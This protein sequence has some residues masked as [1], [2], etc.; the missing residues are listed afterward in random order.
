M[1]SHSGPS[2]EGPLPRTSIVV[3]AVLAISCTGAPKP[4]PCNDC[5]PWTPAPIPRP[6]ASGAASAVPQAAAV[7]SAPAIYS[8]EQLLKVR[9]GTAPRAIDDQAFVYLYDAPGTAQLHLPAAK[10]GDAPKQLT[11]YTDRVSNLRVAPGG[12]ELVFLKDQGGDENDQL[13]RLDLTGKEKDAVALT[14]RPKVKHTLPVF[15]GAAK[16]IAFTSNGRNGKDMDLYVQAWPGKPEDPG[17]AN[18]PLVEVSGNY[19][20]AD[21]VGERVLLVE[22]RSN[23]DQD[24]WVVDV[25]SKNKKLL[26]KHTGDERYESARFSRDGK[27]V[28]VLTD[29][30]REFMSLVAIDVASGARTSVIA[31][32]HD[33]MALSMPRWNAPA[34]KGEPDDVAVFGVNV[35]G[36]EKV[37]VVTLDNKRKVVKRSEPKADGVIGTIDVAPSG[38]VAY[39]SLESSTHPT[40]VYRLDLES[41]ELSR[42]TFGDHA[43]VDEGKL[44]DHKLSSFKSFDGKTISY[45]SW[46]SGG[47][48]ARMPVVIEIHGGPESQAQPWFSGV[49]QYLALS[50]YMVVAPNVRGSLGY[51]KAFAHL[52]DKD[53][54]EDSVRDISEL[55]KHLSTMPAVDPKRIALYG[56]SYGG[57]MVLAG[58]TLFP[59]QWAAGVDVVGIANFKTFL[60]QTAPYRRALR[61]AEY[62]SLDKDAA[63]LD[64]ISPIHKVDKIRAPL[65]VIHG[66]NDPRVPIGEAKQ[67]ATALE[68]RGVPVA[69]M[70]FE[71]EGHGLSK[72]KNRLVAYPA[73]VKFLDQY[74]KTKK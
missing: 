54:R 52:D 11:S 1:R 46:S 3:A 43:G 4:P 62:G 32:D 47:D 61:E 25:K 26:T 36:V 34:K 40:D 8:I 14:A 70:T 68:K 59:D 65:M 18:K 58:L 74:V 2:P 33:L 20:A 66:T 64:K 30:G 19:H 57:Y 27:V 50:G 73:V 45:F 29:A 49:R 37:S 10:E 63:L 71:D 67:I 7:E 72:L 69:L 13:Y 21:F 60:E 51:G 12:K 56:G 23:V 22:A 35:D 15:D 48:A 9:R 5:T 31:E 42:R 55:G 24:V 6:S 44:V 17:A 53:K 28:Y 41:G 38:R 39:V 16:R